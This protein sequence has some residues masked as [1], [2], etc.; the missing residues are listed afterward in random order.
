[1]GENFDEWDYNTLNS[2]VGVHAGAVA[3]WL[4]ALGTDPVWVCIVC[5]FRLGECVWS[6]HGNKDEGYQR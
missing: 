5:R 2:H 6:V 3:A 4:R 1:M